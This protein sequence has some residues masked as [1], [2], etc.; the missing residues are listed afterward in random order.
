[1]NVDELGA[2]AMSRLIKDLEKEA[3]EAK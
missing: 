2:T 1:M 3:I